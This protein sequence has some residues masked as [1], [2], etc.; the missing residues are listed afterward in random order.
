MAINEAGRN[1]T[2]A[3]IMLLCTYLF[4]SPHSI[5]VGVSNVLDSIAINQKA[6]FMCIQ[7]ILCCWKNTGVAKQV[8]RGH[9]P[10]L[11]ELSLG[12]LLLQCT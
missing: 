8:L 6:I 4:R 2:S 5:V 12:S 3:N 7:I 9:S 11:I 1:K 10:E